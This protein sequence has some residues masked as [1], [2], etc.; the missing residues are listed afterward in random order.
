MINHHT[1][2]KAGAA[3]HGNVGDPCLEGRHEGL[4][5]VSFKPRGVTRLL[6]ANP[7]AIPRPL[8][9]GVPLTRKR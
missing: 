3:G 9:P 5:M 4:V 6:P 2:K 7:A 8:F 1:Q